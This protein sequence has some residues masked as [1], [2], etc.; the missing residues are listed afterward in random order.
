MNSQKNLP[1][2]NKNAAKTLAVM[3]LV[4]AVAAFFVS[5]VLCYVFGCLSIV[6]AAVAKKLGYSGKIP[7][8]AIVFAAVAVILQ[9]LFDIFFD[10]LVEK[11][12]E[13]IL[14][15]LGW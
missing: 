13:F 6:F 12:F 10:S 2:N 9:L 11:G 14:S 7:V 8:I 5:S 3:S 15:Q 1:E 4:L